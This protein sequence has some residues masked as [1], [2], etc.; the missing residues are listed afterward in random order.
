MLKPAGTFAQLLWRRLRCFCA[1]ARAG[2]AAIEF[3]LVMPILAL[4]LFGLIETGVIYFFS[5]TLTNAANDTARMVR[6]GQVQTQDMTRSQYIAQICSQMTGIV[7][8]TSCNSNLQVDMESFSSFTN[9]NYTNVVNSDGSLNIGAMQFVAGD[10]CDTVLVRAFYPWSIMT[11]FMSKLLAN[12]PNGQ[13]LMT[14][15][16]AFRNEPYVAGSTC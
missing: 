6:T 1:G 15:A 4:F 13:Y 9:A 8:A 16:A 3:A 11:P 12:M 10:S 14:S 5:S 2:S 7:S